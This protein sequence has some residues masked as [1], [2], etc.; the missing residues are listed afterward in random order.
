MTTKQ[1]TLIRSGNVIAIHPAV[2]ELC[3]ELE[4]ILTY[5]YVQ[6]LRGFEARRQ[7]R[8]FDFI[9]VKCYQYMPPDERV[10]FVTSFGYFEKISTV[11]QK[12]GYT[13]TMQ[14]VSTVPEKVWTPDWSAVEDV[15]FRWRQKELIETILSKPHGRID[16][17][18]GYGKSFVVRILAKILP[19]AIIHITT[20]STK[21]LRDFY[22]DLR[23]ELPSVGLVGA[24]CDI[25]DKRVQI[26]GAMSLR[27][28][29]GNADFLFADEGHELATSSVLEVLAKKYRYS[30]CYMFSASQNARSDNR[31]FELEGIFGPVIMKIGYEE[32]LQHK[33][34][35]PIEVRWSN[36][37]ISRNPCL[38]ANNERYEDV[39]LKRRGLWRNHERNAVI[40]ADARKYDEQT[41]V[42][43]VTETIEHAI[44]LKQWLPE[45]TLVYSAQG[46]SIEEYSAYVKAKYLNEETDPIMTDKRKRL[47]EKQFASGELKKVIATGVWN[48][49]VNFPQLAVLIR[50]DGGGSTINDTQI[51][52][53]VCR[54][55]EDK[56]VGIVH[57]YLDQFDP[58]FSRRATARMRNYREKGWTQ[59]LPENSNSYFSK[60]MLL[61]G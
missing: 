53:R 33:M 24:G 40:A 12:L 18:T 42:L 31:D 48:R 16:C 37:F 20:K 55:A 4:Q 41:Q 43:I 38:N 9:K 47:L 13:W 46:L 19:T 21:I 32:A 8:K 39:Y 27:H 28:S 3:A 36:V 26:Y 52:G 57:D 17:P 54:L 7:G 35:V 34:V 25:N 29:V 15:N 30:R 61:G 56:S 2:P 51:P 59:I 10:N 11:L 6:Q 60:S 49:G 1:V 44:N 23:T 50:A 45:F 5:T 58:G 22:D 14:N